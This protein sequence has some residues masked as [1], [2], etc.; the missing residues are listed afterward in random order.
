ML[1]GESFIW[2]PQK[3]AD[4]LYSEEEHDLQSN[5]RLL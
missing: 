5:C 3:G 4:F 2:K 1:K